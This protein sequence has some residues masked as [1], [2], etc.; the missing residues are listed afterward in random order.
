MRR[1]RV[2]WR[3][4]LGTFAPA[5]RDADLAA[6]LETHINLHLDDQVQAGM[7]REEARRQAVLTLGGIESTRD[8]IRD[9]RG[10]PMIDTVWLDLKYAFTGM[11]R[12]P[13]LTAV[14]VMTLALGIGANTAILSILNSV[15]LR[16]LAYPRP[17]Q[18]MSLNTSPQLPVSVPEYF[19]FQQFNRSF[20]DVGAFRTGEVNLMAGDR[21]L[22]VHSAIVDAHLLKALGVR[23][24]EGRLFSGDDSVVSAPELP[25]G[26][27][28]TAAVV[29]ISYEL[30]Q[31][32]FGAR[33]IIGGSVNVDGRRLEVVGI[34][35]RSADLMDTQTEIWL[36]LGF[37]NE[38][39]LARNNHN[40]ALIGR[41]KEGVTVTSAQAELNA[42][43]ETW[44]ARAG[45]TPGGGQAGH[46][47]LPLANDKGH[48]L[49]MT[50]LAD[51]ILGRAGQSL[52]V[53]QAA[54][55]L[56]LLIA[57]ANVVN[58]LLAR[59]ETRRRE[60]AVLTALGAGR[61]RLLRKVL[62]ES[63]LLSVAGGALGVLVARAGVEALVRAYPAGL[64]RIGEATVDLRV[65]VV[66][67]A[68]AVVCGLLFGLASMMPGRSAGIA[69]TLK[70][71]PRGS[72]GATRHHV[73]R[74]LVTAE[75]AL[76]VIVVVGAG[77]LLRTVHN[78]TAVDAGFDRS[79]LVTFSITLPRTS[80]DLLGRV[81]A[82]QR[83]LNELGAVPGV[84]GASAMTSLPLDR[85][86]APN[87]TEITNNAAASGL[88]IPIDYQRVMS[89]YFDTMGIPIL[90]GRGFQPTDAVSEGGVAVV[91]ET[92][93]N[94]YWR[95]RNPIGQQLRPA[96][97]NPWFTVIGVAKDV[98]QD[99]VDQSVGAEAYVLLDQIATDSP[100]TWVAISPTTMHMVA[101]TTL[102]L[103]TLAPMIA[104][105]VRNIDPAVPVARVREMEEVFAESIRRPRLLAQLVGAFGGLA[106][107][108]AAIGTYGVL[109]YM[110]AERRREIGIRMALG[111]SRSRVLAQVMAQGV[112]LTTMG[113]TVGLA[114]ALALNRL[115][116]SLLFGVEAT[117]ITTLAGVTA[118][119]TLVAAAACW[120]PARRAS[121]IDPA[122]VLR[123]E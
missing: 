78:L 91:N 23:P 103:A 51:Q 96:S 97:T 39:R 15:L 25:G 6:E 26:S 56:V 14:V 28:V 60:F 84:H 88:S 117:D 3:R 106:L 74:A 13:G 61:S 16:P 122:Q 2:A 111:A 36:P 50:P 121:L 75:T 108:L 98:K 58:L 99:G 54:V 18:L 21:A 112:L 46:V 72:S 62:T 80:F 63:V 79:R 110:V 9:R 81:R 64:P 43:I 83:L 73:R 20:A 27:A 65:M 77:L 116:A 52:W 42:L 35:A 22:R 120:L 69:E 89:G 70:S 82:Y 92:M 1:L 71:G 119:M 85:S 95:G 4:L 37:T 17:A 41:L 40:L 55:G 118:T 33:P 100:T 8:Q 104:Q 53:L 48:I 76:A 5:R 67:L 109:S 101:R 114:G 57:C 59:A 29:V 31:S 10:M 107:L 115:I 86:F 47:F 30:W 12:M 68:I 113:I 90:Q 19:E 34:M 32:A 94:T 93:A 87:Q 49:Q 66:S 105:V 102:P 24:V 45:I 7:S 123:S 44:A 38:E 11:R